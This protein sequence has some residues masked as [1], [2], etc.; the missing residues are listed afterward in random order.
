M[1]AGILGSL[2]AGLS[3]P[4]WARYLGVVPILAGAAIAWPARRT[5]GPRLALGLLL[6]ATGLLILAAA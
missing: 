2:V 1:T 5:R 4:D 6:A 3:W